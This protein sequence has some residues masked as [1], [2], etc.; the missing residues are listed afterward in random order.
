MSED[1]KLK[2]AAS[3]PL[4][5]AVVTGGSGGIGQAVVARL[6]RD[7]FTTVSWSRRPAVPCTTAHMALDV[8]DAAAVDR[9]AARTVTECGAIRALVVNAG[10]QGPIK[11]LWEIGPD[12]F[13]HVIETNLVSAHLTLRAVVPLMLAN[14]GPD[15]GR[16][17]L[18]SSVQGKEGT[19]LAG[20]YAASKAGMI[21]LGKTL[22]KELA[23]KGIL[24]NV[25]TP[26]VVRSTMETALSPERRQDL[27]A[28]IP[29]G[30]FLEPEEVAAMVSWL[31]GSDC[32][33]STGA[34]FDLSGGRT[35]Y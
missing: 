35:T 12:E 29:M 26:T 24:V 15:R 6:S 17:V 1:E 14:D 9:T 2:T 16:I 30:R 13:R 10:I 4:G 32:T 28:R 21:A 22:G 20:A 23:D 8:T 18:V 31:C 5:V 19:A 11:P 7:G 27:L 3:N 33:A 25:V 34:V